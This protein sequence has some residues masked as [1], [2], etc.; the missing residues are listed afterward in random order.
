MLQVVLFVCF[1]I[2]H[3]TFW[4]YD[5]AENTVKV[6]KSV[7]KKVKHLTKMRKLHWVPWPQINVFEYQSQVCLS[8]V[9][10]SEVDFSVFTC[11]NCTV[12]HKPKYQ[13]AVFNLWILCVFVGCGVPLSDKAELPAKA[14][15]PHRLRTKRCS[16]NSWEDKEC[17]YF[18]HLDIIWINTP[19]WACK[20]LQTY[21]QKAAYCGGGCILGMTSNTSTLQIVSCPYSKLLPYGLGSPLSRR[22]RRSSD[23]CECLNPA[24]KTCSGFCHKR[25]VSPFL[26]PSNEELPVT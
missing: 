3:L 16:C 15:H 23:R 19:R 21:I 12:K 18:C 7:K 25:S 10:L 6:L 17:I 2:N 13:P 20:G 24:D 4:F 26:Y 11:D 14:A 1:L 22:R 9:N 8:G 5:S